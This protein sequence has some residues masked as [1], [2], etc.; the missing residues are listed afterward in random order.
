MIWR[1][2][3][4]IMHSSCKCAWWT[5]FGTYSTYF[6][7]KA[8]WACKMYMNWYMMWYLKKDMFCKEHDLF[9][10]FV[11]F[12][13]V[14]PSSIFWLVWP[15]SVVQW[16]RSTWNSFM[17]LRIFL[18]TWNFMI[19][20]MIVFCNRM[21][22]HTNNLFS[23]SRVQTPGLAHDLFCGS[24]VR[25]PDPIACFRPVVSMAYVTCPHN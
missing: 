4:V 10:W 20:C 15:A 23:R 5:F 13:T 9:G 8:D 7:L 1:Q 17:H 11:I 2:N 24:R 12:K 19:V 16:T 21:H 25:F 14:C 3:T 6:L 18:L 22:D